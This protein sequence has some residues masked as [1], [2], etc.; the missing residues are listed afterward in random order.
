MLLRLSGWMQGFQVG[1]TGSCYP[2]GT[3]SMESTKE[4]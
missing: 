4:N 1:L 3:C 2:F